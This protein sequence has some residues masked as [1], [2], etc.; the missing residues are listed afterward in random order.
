MFYSGTVSD[1]TPASIRPHGPPLSGTRG[2]A[3]PLAALPSAGSSTVSHGSQVSRLHRL[4]FSFPGLAV[5]PRRKV[6]LCHQWVRPRRCGPHRRGARHGRAACHL[7]ART[8][9][10]LGLTSSASVTGA[11]SPL[12]GV[13]QGPMA[14][15][16]H[17]E[18]GHI[19]STETNREICL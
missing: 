2:R 8:P 16:I 3:L 11:C 14:K 10:G 13:T 15:Q 1:G 6:L 4:A 18:H 19:A 17:R 12:A 7:L 9:A 5:R